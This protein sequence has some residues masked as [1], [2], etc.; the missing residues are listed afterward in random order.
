M[1]EPE[2]LKW[3]WLLS[4]SILLLPPVSISALFLIADLTD[5]L[6]ARQKNK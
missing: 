1:T 4:V 6:S 3:L 5:A 2:Y